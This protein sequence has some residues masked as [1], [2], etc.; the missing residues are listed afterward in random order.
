MTE[1]SASDHERA[2]RAFADAVSGRLGDTLDSVVVFG[3]TVRGDQRGR[4]SDVDVLV[5]VRDGADRRTTRETLHEVAYEGLLDHGIV[6]STH[7][8]TSSQ[9][10]SDRDHPFLRNIRREGRVYG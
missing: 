1:D 5:I 9:Y 8:L 6:V 7:L 4:D 3:S 2:A 10:E